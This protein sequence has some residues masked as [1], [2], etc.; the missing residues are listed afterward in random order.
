MSLQNRNTRVAKLTPGDHGDV[1]WTVSFTDN[2]LEEFL[3]SP[4][5]FVLDK[6]HDDHS[7]D[8]MDPTTGRTTGRLFRGPLVFLNNFPI[9]IQFIYST[10]RGNEEEIAK[11][12]YLV[13]GI[14]GTNRMTV[15]CPQPDIIDWEEVSME[16][17]VADEVKSLI[18]DIGK[19]NIDP[20]IF[21]GSPIGFVHYELP[22]RDQLRLLRLTADFIRNPG[23]IAAYLNYSHV[24]D[25]KYKIGQGNPRTASSRYIR[26]K[27][28]EG[29]RLY[30]FRFSYTTRPANREAWNHNSNL[31]LSDR[32]PNAVSVRED[33]NDAKPQFMLFGLA[34]C[35]QFTCSVEDDPQTGIV[36]MTLE[37]GTQIRWLPKPIVDNVTAV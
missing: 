7:Y 2:Q 17:S 31:E 25:R 19:I 5:A 33:G 30:N 22:G 20:I 28:P 21:D 26:F 4:S 32:E 11:N 36:I 27:M 23:V 35:M 18:Q 34:D 14:S 10:P 16:R 3:N 13:T 37:D 6:C 1:F 15:H 9:T 24:T 8:P 12:V 29:K